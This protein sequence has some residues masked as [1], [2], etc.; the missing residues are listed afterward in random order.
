MYRRHYRP[1]L[2][3]CRE[4]RFL[5]PGNLEGQPKSLGA[6]AKQVCELIHGEVGVRINFH[7][8]RK[9][10]GSWLLQETR[11]PDLV[12]ALLGHKD[13]SSVTRL[14]AE[15]QSA[16]AVEALDAR[17]EQMLARAGVHLPR[18]ATTK[19]RRG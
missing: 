17:V 5:F 18:R 14:Y 7:L 9:I 12:A 13:G 1:L 6:L 10:I 19:G 15:F 8:L 4:D 2:V 3:T 11:D 16:W